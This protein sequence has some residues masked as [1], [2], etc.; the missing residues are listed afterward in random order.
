MS[1]KKFRRAL[2]AAALAG[3]A[4]MGAKKFGVSGKG[5]AAGDGIDDVVKKAVK[6]SGKTFGVDAPT[7]TPPMPKPRMRASKNKLMGINFGTTTT[8]SNIDA[9]KKAEK[10]R[11]KATGFARNVKNKTMM[12][13]FGA[14]D[15]FTG[16]GAKTGKFVT[17]KAKLGRNKKTKLS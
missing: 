9:F 11:R 1:K 4:Y 17:A 13:G 7:G 6:P 3:A 14:D 16:L 2:K 8:P 12:A 5:T 10:A 15:A